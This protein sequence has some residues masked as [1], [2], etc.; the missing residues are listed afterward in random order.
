MSVKVKVVDY[1]PGQ[2]YELPIE[3]IESV[4]NHHANIIILKEKFNL[5]SSLRV[6]EFFRT[7]DNFS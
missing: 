2:L 4:L 5:T 6:Y 1:Q 7:K 3:N